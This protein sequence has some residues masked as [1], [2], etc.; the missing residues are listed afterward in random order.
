MGTARTV[1]KPSEPLFF[2][3]ADPL[4][5]KITRGMPPL[6]GLGDVPAGKVSISFV[7]ALGL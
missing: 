7:F 6:G 3:A 4:A 2:K 1:L 5:D